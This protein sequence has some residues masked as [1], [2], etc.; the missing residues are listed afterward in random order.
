[1][2]TITIML[3]FIYKLS[4]WLMVS[5]VFIILLGAILA[6]YT[7]FSLLHTMTVIGTITELIEEKDNNGKICEIPVFSFKDTKGD[8]LQIQSSTL[9]FLS[10][11]VKIGDKYELLYNPKKR[12]DEE[13]NR[14]E[15]ILVMGYGLFNFLFFLI[16]TFVIKRMLSSANKNNVTQ[17]YT[18]TPTNAQRVIL[19]FTKCLMALLTLGIVGGIFGLIYIITFIMYA[20]PTIGT[21]VEIKQ[22]RIGNSQEFNYVPFFTF[23]DAKGIM[24]KV[25]SSGD[26]ISSPEIGEKVEILYNPINPDY[27]IENS[28]WCLWGPLIQGIVCFFIL[29]FVMTI[30]KRKKIFMRGLV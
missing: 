18:V 26:A 3:A 9:S 2:G 6:I 5:F 22:E 14:L 10:G 12:S 30:A 7:H 11:Q 4:K 1:M 8:I 21:I 17:N 13:G 23:Q 20:V 25:R 19:L 15:G 28:F 16:M 24:H 27:A 29:G